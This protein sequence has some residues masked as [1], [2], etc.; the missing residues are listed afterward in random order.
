MS[1]RSHALPSLPV[2]TGRRRESL[3]QTEQSSRAVWQR[4]R[5]SLGVRL[6]VEFGMWSLDCWPLIVSVLKEGFFMKQVPFQILWSSKRHLLT[7]ILLENFTRGVGGRKHS[8]GYNPRSQHA[9]TWM[10]GDTAYIYM[11]MCVQENI[12]NAKSH[13]VVGELHVAAEKR[14]QRRKYTSKPQFVSCY[15][16]GLAWCQKTKHEFLE[17]SPVFF[18]NISLR[19]LCVIFFMIH[20]HNPAWCLKMNVDVWKRRLLF[21]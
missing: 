19:T 1:S 16:H 6:C 12:A 14:K 13:P 7:D 17:A 10:V 5:R 9:A 11:W 18:V 21:C 8:I 15:R 2:Y 20:T 3:Q 4:G